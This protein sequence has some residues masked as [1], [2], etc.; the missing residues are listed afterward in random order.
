M[1]AEID[2]QKKA[3]ALRKL[4]KSIIWIAE[5]LG[6][7]K[8]S[9]YGWTKQMPVPAR[10]TRE[11]RA[12]R[13]Q[14]RLEKS[15]RVQEKNRR[16]RVYGSTAGYRKVIRAPDDYKGKTHKKG[17]YVYAHRYLMEQHLGRLLRPG[18]I[19]HHKND[20][21]MDNK[22]NNLGV[23]QHAIHSRE[24]SAARGRKYVVLRCPECDE[25]FER[26]ENHSFLQTGGE[27]TCCSRR[28]KGSFGRRLALE[29]RTTW[30]KKAIK[31]NLVRRYRKYP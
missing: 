6:V 8:S 19:V 3:R 5:E 25:Q 26:T 27:Y 11:Y 2:K 12:R 9:V 13:K 22:I 29:G 20:D 30:A 23:K 14:K 4:G 17:R 1:K 18:E 24:H 7:S 10:L 21:V 28:C 31:R 15:K 16:N